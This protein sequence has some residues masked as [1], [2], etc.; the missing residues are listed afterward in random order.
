MNGNG[1]NKSTTSFQVRDCALVTMATGFAVQN[2]RE[3]RDCL[4]RVH[5]GSIYHH[6]W[7][8][9]L[10]PQFDEPEYNNDFAAWIYHALHEKALAERLSVL[11]P[12]EFQDIE[13]LRQELIDRVEDYLYEKEI[14]PWSM[15]DQQFH[16]VRS[17]IVVLDTGI[18][19]EHPSQLTDIL[20]NLSLGS[21]FY[22]FIDARKRTEEKNDDF[23]SWLTGWGDMYEDLRL[24]ILAMDPYFS[25]LKELRW[26]LASLFKDFFKENTNE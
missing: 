10:Q 25:S 13:E 20:E 18:M 2:L 26:M 16:F 14:V 8:R 9:F 17:Q 7:G 15:A 24:D 11:D 12:T 5:E 22:H 1:K 3:F 21:I 23:S 6:F 4:E 19:L